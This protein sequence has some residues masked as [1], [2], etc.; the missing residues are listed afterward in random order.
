MNSPDRQQNNS[1]TR[2][3]RYF[4]VGLADRLKED[5]DPTILDFVVDE[6]DRRQHLVEVVADLQNVV[7][8]LG[9][10][11]RLMEVVGPPDYQRAVATRLVQL[12]DA[13]LAL[14]ETDEERT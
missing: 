12:Q 13:L 2:Y 8:Q 7:N 6:L 14:T 10:P 5:P 9:V 4:P 3:L 1:P 11:L